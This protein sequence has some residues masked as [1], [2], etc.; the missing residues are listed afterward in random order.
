[1]KKAGAAC[2]GAQRCADAHTAAPAASTWCTSLHT[3]R[4]LYRRVCV[5]RSPLISNLAPDF[6]NMTSLSCA[7]DGTTIGDDSSAGVQMI[8]EPELRVPDFAKAG[9]DIISVH[10]ETAATIHLHR[11][12]NQIK[13]R[14]L[15]RLSLRKQCSSPR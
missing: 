13:V 14:A 15:R 10:A 12:L 9:A 4:Y 6:H 1:V 11:T 7:R 8:V 3:L 2:S 5:A